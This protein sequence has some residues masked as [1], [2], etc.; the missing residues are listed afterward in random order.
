MLQEGEIKAIRDEIV[1]HEKEAE[2]AYAK[3]EEHQALA[4]ALRTYLAEHDTDE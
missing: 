2:K 3:L 4:K 1:K